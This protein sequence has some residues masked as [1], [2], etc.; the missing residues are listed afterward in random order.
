M[1]KADIS[2]RQGLSVV[3]NEEFKDV[4]PKCALRR[5][6]FRHRMSTADEWT[7]RRI[8]Q[9]LHEYFDKKVSCIRESYILRIIRKE[10]L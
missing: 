4:G 7:E 10:G 5:F 2:A 8:E 1:K 3:D 6:I 9:S